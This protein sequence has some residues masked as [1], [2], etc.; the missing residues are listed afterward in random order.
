MYRKKPK[1]FDMSRSILPST[2]RKSAR[3]N[4]RKLH[5][6]NRSDVRSKLVKYKGPASEVIEQEEQEQVDLSHHWTPKDRLGYDS[7]VHDRREAD[8]VNH[9]VRWATEITKDMEPE[10]AWSYL[11]SV[12]P[13]GLIGNHALTHLYM[14]E[15]HQVTRWW[16]ISRPPS[17]EYLMVKA[18]NES[19]QKKIEEI[20]S[21][22]KLAKKFNHNLS[23][24]HRIQLEALK[25]RTDNQ[26]YYLYHPDLKIKLS[27]EYEEW[28]KDNY[29]LFLKKLVFASWYG[30]RSNHELKVKELT[31]YVS[32]YLKIPIPPI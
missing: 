19:I 15:P 8:K 2:S 3:D 10:D 12:V 25:R 31:K 27:W 14:F 4:K 1:A 5:H 11:Q 26:L 29:E 16:Q 9:F 24:Y 28:T 7:I 18:F 6:K 17:K 13:P 21:N 22:K 20:L 30:Y 32:D 23:N